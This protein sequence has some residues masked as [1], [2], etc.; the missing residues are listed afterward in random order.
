MRK[1]SGGNEKSVEKLFGSTIKSL[2]KTTCKP[3]ACCMGACNRR[4]SRMQ[5]IN[6]WSE[7]EYRVTKLADVY[8]QLM[9]SANIA[10]GMCAGKRKS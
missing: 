10:C 8:A 4:G 3:Q 5:Y 7:Q 9:E 6:S 1:E 2:Q